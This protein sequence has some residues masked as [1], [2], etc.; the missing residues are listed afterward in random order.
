M[1]DMEKE[2]MPPRDS[3]AERDGGAGVLPKIPT[4][5]VSAW[6]W[7]NMMSE[8]ERSPEA[9]SALEAGIFNPGRAVSEK[10]SLG[11]ARGGFPEL[12]ALARRI[13]G[14]FSEQSSFRLAVEARPPIDSDAEEL[15]GVFPAH[16]HAG[17]LGWLPH[18]DAEPGDSGIYFT[19]RG[20]FNCINGPDILARWYTP[21]D[22]FLYQP[23][24]Q[25]LRGH[26]SRVN[27]LSV[28]SA[29]LIIS[30]GEDGTVRVWRGGK[31]GFSST[32]LRGHE[33]PVNGTTVL[34]DGRIISWSDDKTVRVWALHPSEPPTC[35]ILRGHSAPIED[36]LLL[37]NGSLVSLGGTEALFWGYQ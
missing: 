19:D 2:K 25:R 32:V 22:P 23:D 11:L 10:V 28:V 14:A 13:G 1:A 37:Q 27:T 20:T 24:P 17:A 3:K 16:R 7:P 30:S 4:P 26:T 31:G 21:E 6:R 8:L 9:R 12:S 35:Q 5:E 15:A 33:G 36:V 29:G 18:T 34:P